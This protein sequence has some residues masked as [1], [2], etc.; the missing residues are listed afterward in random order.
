[1]PNYSY[2]GIDKNNKKVK[3]KEVAKSKKDLY[4]NLKDAGICAFDIEET[5]EKTQDLY[6]FK[7]KELSEFSRQI[8]TMQASGIPVI[9]AIS[10]ISETDLKPQVKKV[11]EH[12]Y[13]VVNDGNTLSEAMRS[14]GTSFPDLMINM[15][16]AG[17][18]SGRLDETALKM[19]TYYESE[20]KI[21]GKM[22]SA[23]AYPIVLAI[24]TVLMIVML[25]TYVM[26]VFT[27]MYEDSGT[28]LHWLTQGLMDF[29]D[30]VIANWIAA[31][32][33]VIGSI[34]AV[35]ELRKIYFISVKIDKTKLKIPKM[36]HLFSIIYTS[37]FARTLSSLYTSGI[38]MIDA[39]EVSTSTVGN[40]YMEIQL[41]AAETRIR[42]GF[43][44]SVALADIEGI[45][46]K[47]MA[48]IYIGEES[49]RLDEML[50]SSSNE[51]EYEANMAIDQLLNYLEPLMIVLMGFI[52]GPVLV[53]VM[54]P[55]FNMYEMF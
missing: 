20:N 8:A 52:I 35:N 6:K 37:R 23:M 27:E 53:G 14:C 50:M 21:R 36:N 3:G 13:Q 43:P 47:L 51:Y 38:S 1:M 40:K 17:E 15:Y 12:L 5:I 44:L 34:V 33:L 42:S 45:D 7:L 25:F 31:I 9:K 2:K 41:R 10:I 54:L 32:L 19:A 16:H 29:S 24:V 46:R 39:V 55:M 18:V 49:G 48:A 11:V 22:R 30:F 4:E 28:D 26:P